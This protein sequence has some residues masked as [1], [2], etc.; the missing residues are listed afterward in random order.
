MAE[1]T[2]GE[3]PSDEQSPGDPSPRKRGDDSAAWYRL[4]GV[5]L[6]F[7]VAILAFGFIGRW[8][9][10]KIGTAPWLMVGGFCLGFVAGMMILIRAAKQI[11]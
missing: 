9:D 10:G 4:A 2:P 5:G 6:E 1:P 3:P 8:I 7:V 11:L